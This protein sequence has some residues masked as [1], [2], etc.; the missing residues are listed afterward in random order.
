MFYGVICFYWA[1]E[2]CCGIGELDPVGLWFPIFTVMSKLILIT[3]GKS[4]RTNTRNKLHSSPTT[5]R[6]KASK[7]EQ[8][9]AIN[10]QHFCRTVYRHRNGFRWY[11]HQKTWRDGS[12]HTLTATNYHVHPSLFLSHLSLVSFQ[13][14][15]DTIKAHKKANT[16]RFLFGSFSFVRWLTHKQLF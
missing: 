2:I 5:W 16:I 10:F 7:P 1:G 4:W 12:Q 6:Q 15:C 13:F 11:I 14:H 9:H 3:N 8:M